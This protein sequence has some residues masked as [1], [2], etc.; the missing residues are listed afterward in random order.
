MLKE[1]FGVKKRFLT[2]VQ[3]SVG[4][5]IILICVL[6]TVATC[7]GDTE[8]T[9]EELTT[10]APLEE[11]AITLVLNEGQEK[12][13]SN[14]AEEAKTEEYLGEMEIAAYCSCKRCIKDSDGY[15]TYSG[16]RPS[17]GLTV[18][19]DLELFQIGDKLRIGDHV[20]EVQD[21]L[22]ARAKEKLS[23]YF[24]NHEEALAF[25]RTKLPVYLLHQEEMHDGTS[26]G[27]FE[28]TGY[29]SCEECCGEKEVYLTKSETIPKSEHTVAADL[30][31]LEMGTKIEIDGVVYTVE[32][33]GK[34]VKGNVIDIY[35]D[36]HEE[37]VRFGRQK[38]E[39]YLVQ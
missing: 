39:V 35:F 17:Q 32:D 25:G 33:T 14:L 30:S 28:I 24:D 22:S 18:A 27:V 4:A 6:T 12:T 13:S 36:T 23:L 1:H 10:I 37:A 7:N 8:T 20:Y 29:C 38:K 9:G 34:R 3:C 11:R 16:Q 5:V 15:T 31:I 26:L 21:K 2:A 19:A